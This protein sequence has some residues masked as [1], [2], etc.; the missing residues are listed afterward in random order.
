MGENLAKFYSTELGKLTAWF[1]RKKLAKLWGAAQGKKILCL[2]YTQPFSKA[3]AKNNTLIFPEADNEIKLPYRDA[4]FEGILAIHYA[5]NQENFEEALE[6]IWR[7]LE[8][9]GHFLLIIVNKYGLWRWSKIRGR[10]LYSKH[11]ILNLLMF[12][13]FAPR[14]FDRALFFP[15]IKLYSILKFLDNIGSFIWRPFSGLL[16]FE[17]EKLIF[18]PRGRLLKVTPSIKELLARKKIPAQAKDIA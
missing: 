12:N 9:N 17:S 7:V 5:G 16:I 8:P 4:E 15:P 13:K 14:R 11:D 3:I 18:A 10:E 1:I 2:G 6:E